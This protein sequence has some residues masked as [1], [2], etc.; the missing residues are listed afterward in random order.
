MDG[1]R[2]PLSAA[3]SAATRAHQP[4]RPPYPPRVN[5]DTLAHLTKLLKDSEGFPNHAAHLTNGELDVLIQA[6]MNKKWSFE[7]LGDKLAHQQLLVL[8]AEG[9]GRPLDTV[10]GLVIAQDP[11]PAEGDDAELAE[12]IALSLGEARVAA[13]EA[14][15]RAEVAREKVKAAV[16]IIFRVC[17]SM[18]FAVHQGTQ[19]DLSEGECIA[20]GCIAL[21]M[22]AIADLR[23][24]RPWGS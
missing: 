3:F 11:Q 8:Q 14:R 23:R 7:L 9:A 22:C 24:P 4:H 2:Q 21:I 17:L 16:S 15:T 13:P 19:M 1:A 20:L 18:T 5:G 12:A 6:L 10:E